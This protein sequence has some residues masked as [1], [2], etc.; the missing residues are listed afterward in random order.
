MR[1]WIRKE[2]LYDLYEG[3][4]TRSDRFRYGLLIADLVMILY[5]IGSSFFERQ[6]AI[7]AVDV[8]FGLYLLADYAAR[9]WLAPDKASFIVHPLNIADVI[10]MISFIA[11]LLGL[12]FG[13]LRILRVLRLMRSYR[14]LARL[15]ADF[16]FFQRNED[17]VNSTLN[18]FIFIFIMTEI[19]LVTQKHGN[20]DVSNF[21]DAMYFS[22]TALTT[23]GFGDITLQGDSGRMVSIIVMIFGVSL[24][25]RLIQTVFRPSKVRFVCDDCGL[26]LHEADAVHC[27]HCGRVLNIPSSG[28]P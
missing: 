16:P 12:D 10:A 13:F 20:P 28:A 6:S 4:S 11:P 8:L 17:I 27:K 24:F 2:T 1:P 7:L 18:L 5:L 25:L 21:L 14:L 23:T 26:Y 22:I 3:E 9:L 19:V 15:R